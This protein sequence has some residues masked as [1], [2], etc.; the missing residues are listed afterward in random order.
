MI[1]ASSCRQSN[2]S[3]NDWAGRDQSKTLEAIYSCYDFMYYGLC[4]CSCEGWSRTGL[5]ISTITSH[6]CCLFLRI[7]EGTSLSFSC[8]WVP[9][10]SHV[11]CIFYVQCFT[12][13]SHV[14]SFNA[15]PSSLYFMFLIVW[16]QLIVSLCTLYIILTIQ[17]S[18]FA[19]PV[20]VEQPNFSK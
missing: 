20:I 16:T 13:S 15:L 5:P 7:L 6:V 17:T 8:F 9:F 1:V 4:M 18:L 12:L 2:N 3:R 14:E 19:T 11:S 10:L